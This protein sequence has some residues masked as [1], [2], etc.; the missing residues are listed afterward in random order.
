MENH[1]YLSYYCII[2]ISK[3]FEFAIFQNLSK[4]GLTKT[5]D[6]TQNQLQLSRKLKALGHP[7]RLAI[8]EILIN[9]ATCICGDLVSELPLSQP[10]ISQHLRELKE[11]GIIKGSVEGT[12]VCYCIDPEAMNDL[13]PFFENIKSTISNQSTSCC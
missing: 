6:Y 13:L 11:A 2:A 12:T 7:A 8:I 4:M 5:S 1:I 9:R 10:T 3:Y